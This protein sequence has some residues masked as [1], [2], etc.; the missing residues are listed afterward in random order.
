MDRGE[1]PTEQA[2]ERARGYRI[3]RAEDGQ[4]SCVVMRGLGMRDRALRHVAV[5]SP[6]GFEVGY[7]GNGP[8]DL[9]LS[10]LA[11]W[12]DASRAPERYRWPEGREA[13]VWDLHQEF[14]RRWLAG[15]QVEPGQRAELAA[16]ELRAFVA[17]HEVA[18]HAERA[19]DWIQE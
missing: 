9:A 2:G 18:H 8:A 10:I 19:A 17:E 7:S 11:D 15:L 4:V 16:H 3:E 1:G 12:L 13:W 14:K 6:T 5:H